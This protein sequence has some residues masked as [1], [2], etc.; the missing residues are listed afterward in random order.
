MRKD[1]VIGKGKHYRIGKLDSGTIQ[2]EIRTTEYGN[3]T[4]S[5]PEGTSVS[6]AHVHA[7]HKKVEMAN[8]P[9]P[10]LARRA[11]KNI[12]L[13]DLINAYKKEKQKTISERDRYSL[14][15]F[16]KYNAPLCEKNLSQGTAIENGIEAY[17]KEKRKTVKGWTITRQ[18]VPLKVM[19][20]NATK[21]KLYGLSDQKLPIY[22]P[23]EKGRIDL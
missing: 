4:F 2:I 14:T 5:L 23:F 6:D 19:Y 3:K 12:S 16:Q 7:I 11:L 17:I 21:N 9:I 8:S 22:N 15:T 18:L 20:N 13:N 10:E 1:Q